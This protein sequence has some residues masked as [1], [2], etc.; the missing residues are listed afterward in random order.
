M[1]IIKAETEPV[2]TLTMVILFRNQNLYF[3][4][5]TFNED[6]KILPFMNICIKIFAHIDTFKNL[7]LYI[8]M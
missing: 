1:T 2:F 3:F 5:A 6:I 7:L 4:T 8:S